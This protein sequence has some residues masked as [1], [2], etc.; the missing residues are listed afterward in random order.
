MYSG[1]IE[2]TNASARAG[3][4]MLWSLL[5]VVAWVSAQAADSGA[6]TDWRPDHRPLGKTLVYICPDLEGNEFEVVT[7]LGPGE[8]AVW[9][10]DRYLVLAQVRSASGVK[11][12]EGEVV[13]WTKADE[14]MLWLAAAE[15]YS[16][17]LDPAR[18]PWADARRRGVSFRA[19]GNE[20]GWYLEVD[21]TGDLLYV[22]NYGATALR[23][24]QPSDHSEGSVRVLADTGGAQQ[25]RVEILEGSC[26]DSM[27]GAVFPYQVIVQLPLASHQGCGRVLTPLTAK[28]LE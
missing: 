12:Q 16:C 7:R 13:F 24:A 19:V 28:A 26:T 11:Y 3:R 2:R 23:I 15:T 10:P 9:L 4:V 17:R 1:L 5:A 20:P 25:L 21:R 22:G 14:A 27:S 18:G 6:P 8:M